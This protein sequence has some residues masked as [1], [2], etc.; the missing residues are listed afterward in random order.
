VYHRSSDWDEPGRCRIM[1]HLSFRPA[2]AEWGGYHAWPY[3]GLSPEW[4]SFVR[5]SNPRQLGLLG[6][7]KPGHP[8]W[9]PETI[10]GVSARY[11]GLDMGPWTL[12]LG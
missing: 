4:H 7:P 6:F 9:T 1:M 3:K 11:P 10:A 5:E 12:A 2:V 8:Y